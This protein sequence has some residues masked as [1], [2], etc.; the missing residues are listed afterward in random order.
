MLLG[1]HRVSKPQ[2]QSCGFRAVGALSCNW[3]SQ[4]VGFGFNLKGLGS[5]YD[6]EIHLLAYPTSPVDSGINDKSPFKISLQ[7]LRLLNVCL[8]S[9]G[10]SDAPLNPKPYTLNH[11]P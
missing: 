5:Q 8:K 11:I 9:L 3:G 6:Q 4:V 7:K 10:S 2:V 1:I